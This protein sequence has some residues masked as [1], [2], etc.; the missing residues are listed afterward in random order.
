M[1]EYRER[2]IRP[3]VRFDTEEAFEEEIVYFADILAEHGPL[4]VPWAVSIAAQVCAVLS[5][6]HAIPVVHRDLKPSN[7]MVDSGGNVK[8]LDFGVAAVLG[9]DVT[10]LTETGRMIGS[11]DYMSPEQ[12][13][14]VGV[15][16]RSDLYALG[17]LLHEML[18]GKKLFDGASDPALQHVHDQ[19]TPLRSL[20][21]RVNQAIEL[22]VLE[23]LEKVPEDRPAS[24]QDVFDRLRPFLPAPGDSGAGLGSYSGALAGGIPDPTRP[25]RHPLSPRR[26][27]VPQVVSQHAP[28]SSGQEAVRRQVLPVTL[29]EQLD[30]AEQQATDLIDQDRFSQAADILDDML[31]SADAI[32]VIDHPRLLETRSTHAVALFLGGDFRRAL[33]AFDELAAAYASVAS[34]HDERVL[35]CRKQAAYCHAELGDTEAA[36]A[37]FQALLNHVQLARDDRSPEALELRHQIGILLLAAH[38]LR[39]AAQVLRPLHQDLLAVRGIEDPDVQEVRDLLTRIQLTGG[40]WR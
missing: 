20:R 24:A 36:L 7:V 38:R 5:Y 35:E 23:L 13:H 40:T 3:S 15:S 4:P 16:P 33:A 18:A 8:V 19:P 37:G 17:C 9:T 6:A 2:P 10:R 30:I 25:Y 12:F 32:A 1:S 26:P 21:P 34:P 27:I 39:E 14:G 28:P 29:V 22:L 11:R 31:S